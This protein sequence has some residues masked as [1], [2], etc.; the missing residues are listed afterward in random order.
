MEKYLTLKKFSQ[1]YPTVP[2]LALTF[3]TFLFIQELEPVLNDGES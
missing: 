1:T 3:L 2:F